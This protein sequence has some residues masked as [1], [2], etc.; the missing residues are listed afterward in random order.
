MADSKELQTQ[1]QLQQQINKVLADR[2]KQMDAITK[3]ISGQAQLQ[4]EL[5]KAMECKELDGLEDRIAGV[6]SSL[7]AAADDA[8]KVGGALNKMGADGQKSAGGLSGALGGVLDKIT[9]V[10]GAAV[11]AGMSIFK[12]F[13]GLPGLIA[14]RHS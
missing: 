8:S 4:K 9:P 5:C 11:G 7:A 14:I 2:A 6:S 10:K 13:K 12:S 1:L 3:Q